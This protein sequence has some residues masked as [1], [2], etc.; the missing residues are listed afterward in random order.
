MADNEDTNDIE[1]NSFSEQVNDDYL[2]P[3][4]RPLCPNC[5]EPC[6]PSLYYCDK[7]GSSLPINPLASYMPFVNIRFN[8]GGF[9]RLWKKIWRNP[10]MPVILKIFYLLVLIL[11]MIL[12]FS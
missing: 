5:L 10:A 12:F 6:D 9:V 8:Y 1:Y 7:C 2:A 4:A 11:F 3:D